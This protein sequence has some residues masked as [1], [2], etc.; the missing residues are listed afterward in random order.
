MCTTNQRG[1]KGTKDRKTRVESTK[2]GNI[3]SCLESDKTEVRTGNIC[4]DHM[5]RT[6]LIGEMSTSTNYFIMRCGLPGNSLGTCRVSV[7][8]L[9]GDPTII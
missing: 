1:D 3:L 2:E 4:R 8:M 5:G 7:L 6:R 9:V